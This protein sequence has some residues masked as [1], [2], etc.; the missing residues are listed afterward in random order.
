MTTEFI[1]C[2]VSLFFLAGIGMPIAYAIMLASFIYLS[3]GGQDIGLSGKILLDGVYSSFILLAVPLFIIAANIIHYAN[4]VKG[5]MVA[6]DSNFNCSAD[7]SCSKYWSE[8]AP[9]AMALQF[10]ENSPL[11]TSDLTTLQGVIGMAPP[12]T[13]TMD[14]QGTFQT[15]V[16]WLIEKYS[17]D[18]DCSAW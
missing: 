7:A 4:D 8:M 14:D 17:L 16:D 6:G 13:N 5:L 10:N 11:S 18:A 3:V 15:V 1:L 9:F 2:I 12:T